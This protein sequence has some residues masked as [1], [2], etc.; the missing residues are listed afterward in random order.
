MRLLSTFTPSPETH[1]A[2]PFLAP[3][4][5][6]RLDQFRNRRYLIDG[7]GFKKKIQNVKENFTNSKT[8]KY[9]HPLFCRHQRL[10]IRICQGTG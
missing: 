1:Q 9:K 5:D 10:R 3:R 2:E 6:T 8:C 4:T 7:D